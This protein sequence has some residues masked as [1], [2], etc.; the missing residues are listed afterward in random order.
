MQLIPAFGARDGYRLVYG[1]DRE[2]TVDELD[3][4]DLNIRL[5]VAYL[6]VL[7]DRYGSLDPQA[8]L[9]L[10]VASYNCGPDFVAQRLPDASIRWGAAEAE[11]WI[12]GATPAETRLFVATVFGR[13]GLYHA[14]IAAVRARALRQGAAFN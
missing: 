12:A 1:V 9:L 3:S 2:P 5:G 10:A 13:A 7:R 8:R 14:A 6:G 4:P 11:A